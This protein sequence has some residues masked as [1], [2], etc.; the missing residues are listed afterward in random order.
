MQRLISEV[1]LDK[2][3]WAARIFKTRQIAV[4]AITSGRIRVNGNRAKPARMIRVG[5]ELCVRK[6]P[7]TYVLT[8]EGL[9]Q[10]RGP[11]RE[12]QALYIESE[13]SV[14]ERERLAKELRTRAAQVLFDPGK[15]D[16]RDRRR[17]RSRKRDQ[18]LSHRG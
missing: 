14:L 12:A 3:L 4:K 17:G 5:D 8:I 1:R 2:W 18:T 9:S 13:S 7:Y 15:P 11:A 6:G 16:K 10:R